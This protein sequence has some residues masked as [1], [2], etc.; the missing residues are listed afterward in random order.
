MKKQVHMQEA[1]DGTINIAK[2][3]RED[4]VGYPHTL[5]IYEDESQ[6]NDAT[7]KFAIGPSMSSYLWRDERQ[8]LDV[9]RGP[10]ET[11]IY[12][13]VNSLTNLH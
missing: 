13:P 4:I 1:I 5:K 11:Y 10:C 2:Y 8:L 7:R 9:D 12:Q 6:E 3:H